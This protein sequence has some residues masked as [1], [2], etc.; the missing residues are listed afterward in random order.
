MT[1]VGYTADTEMTV[2][3]SW[4]LFQHDGVAAFT[5]AERSPLPPPLSA[6]DL[7]GVQTQILNDHRIRCINRHPV[8]SD[9]NS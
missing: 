3:A 2:K 7:P 1:A 5:L 6:K 9:E 8:E 4:L